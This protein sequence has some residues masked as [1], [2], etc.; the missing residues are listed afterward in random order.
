MPRELF[1]SIYKLDK[2]LDYQYTL[3]VTA[4]ISVIIKKD[5]YW[6]ICFEN[7]KSVRGVLLTDHVW[8]R[9]IRPP[10]RKNKVYGA[11]LS[12][13]LWNDTVKK[14]SNVSFEASIVE[15]RTK[16]KIDYQFNKIKEFYVLV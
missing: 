13:H 5:T 9:Q 6:D 14:G 1:K 3:E 2:K 10:M 4:T 15:Y 12:H 7:V 11:R 8:F 16:T